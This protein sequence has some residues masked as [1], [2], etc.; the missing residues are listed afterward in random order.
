ME[1]A[2]GTK[3]RTVVLNKQCLT[4]EDLLTDSMS[5]VLSISLDKPLPDQ[6]CNLHGIWSDVDLLG[7]ETHTAVK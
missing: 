1:T 3:Q 7:T 2:A 5:T 4:G 6:A